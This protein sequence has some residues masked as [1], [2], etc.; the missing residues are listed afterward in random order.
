MPLL[1]HTPK[2]NA[3][4][5]VL[6]KEKT[7]V[8]GSPHLAIT[9]FSDCLQ[10]WGNKKVTLQ[11]VLAFTTLEVYKAKESWSTIISRVAACLAIA[12]LK[13]QVAGPKGGC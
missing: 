12:L 9:L 5:I 3:H 2:G 13:D 7:V 6:N 10:L 8:W 1:F 4:N 11:L